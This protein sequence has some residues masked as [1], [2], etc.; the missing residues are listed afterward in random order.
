MGVE[1]AP[2]EAELYEALVSRGGLLLV[3][4][5]L[6][7]NPEIMRRTIFS[8]G[9]IEYV[10]DEKAAQVLAR[11]DGTTRVKRL[12]SSQSRL[13]SYAELLQALVESPDFDQLGA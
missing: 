8:H 12:G 5:G 10:I 7:G 6:V 3:E 11:R 13:F 2:T 1:L 9:G 4:F